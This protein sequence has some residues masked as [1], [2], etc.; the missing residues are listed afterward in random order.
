MG[1]NDADDDEEEEEDAESI[2]LIDDEGNLFGVVNV[3]DALVVLGVIAVVVAGV[4]LVTGGGGTN[5]GSADA[6]NQTAGELD[7]DTRYI[8]VAFGLQRN[9][10]IDRLLT[11]NTLEVN[12]VNATVSDAYVY[13]TVDPNDPRS[14]LSLRL[15]VNGTITDSQFG[16]QVRVSGN[17]IRVGNKLEFTADGR[18][19]TGSPTSI[20]ESGTELQTERLTTEV[21]IENVDPRMA[22]RIESGQRETN[23]R[24][25]EVATI[26]SV[27]VSDA[28]SG[29]GA[30][31][32]SETEQPS[33]LT[34]EVELLT[35]ETDAGYQFRG[36][37]LREGNKIAFDLGSR[38]VSGTVSEL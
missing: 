3:I 32:D 6:T 4:A 11:G 18:T 21:T 36:S 31:A 35:L 2:Q 27:S 26:Q 10:F 7:Q 30:D 28:G 24:D 34:L 16:E 5:S 14:G 25:E 12:G 20:D 29:A 1:V 38:V 8:T 23:L 22:Y 9:A 33:D 15:A 19:V 13:P 17:R 37:T